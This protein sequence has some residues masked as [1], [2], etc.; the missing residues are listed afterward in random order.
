MST[1]P[2]TYMR[3]RTPL[4]VFQPAVN[5]RLSCRKITCKAFPFVVEEQRVTSYFLLVKKKKR[6]GGESSLPSETL[7]ICVLNFSFTCGWMQRFV[8]C[9]LR[10]FPCFLLEL[11]GRNGWLRSL[12]NGA[13][14]WNKKV[15]LLVVCSAGYECFQPPLFTARSLWLL[16]EKKYIQNVQLFC[17]S[18]FALLFLC[19]SR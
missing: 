8:P 18:L 12:R 19:P 5:Q 10:T 6:G 14:F 4:R 17:D 16:K 7:W 13:R 15:N 2:C 1:V 11:L 9:S 3:R